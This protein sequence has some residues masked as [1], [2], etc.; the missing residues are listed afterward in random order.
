MRALKGLVLAGFALATLS[1]AAAQDASFKPGAYSDVSAIEIVPGQFQNYM[2]YLATNWKK[3]QEFN[4]SKGWITGY[5][6]LVNTYPRAGEPDLYLIVDYVKQYSPEEQLA[7]QKE[8]E[9]FM[10]Q[11]TRQ[12]TTASGERGVMRKLLGQMQ[13]QEAVL[14]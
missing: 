7:Q 6:V 9:A 4:K 2:D 8:F 11:T 1:T 13:L 14:K 5:R 3:A 10:K 12:A